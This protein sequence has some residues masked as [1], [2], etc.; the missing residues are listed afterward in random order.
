[1]EAGIY[2]S[3][4]PLV[5]SQ[6]S[7]YQ[8]V[9]TY[10]NRQ[11]ITYSFRLRCITKLV[12]RTRGMMCHL[13]LSYLH[14]LL[15]RYAHLLNQT[16]RYRLLQGVLVALT[17]L[18]GLLL[19]LLRGNETMRCYGRLAVLLI[20]VTLKLSKTYSTRQLAMG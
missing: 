14:R 5:K 9:L 7:N 20:T 8:R 10:G 11:C 13:L 12:N 2:G 17:V 19:T 18:L 6:P 1:M 15:M 4:N 3:R 16:F